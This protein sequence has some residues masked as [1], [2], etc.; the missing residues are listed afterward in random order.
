LELGRARGIPGKA[1]VRRRAGEKSFR[2]PAEIG[3]AILAA[4]PNTA[5]LYWVDFTVTETW[6]FEAR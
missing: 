3:R 2:P 6:P 5:E 1:G 4:A